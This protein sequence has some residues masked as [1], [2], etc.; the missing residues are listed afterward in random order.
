EG[1]TFLKGTA[2]YFGLGALEIRLALSMSADDINVRKEWWE[3]FVIGVGIKLKDLRLSFAPK[4]EEKKAK[5]D[6]ILWGLQDIL[7]DKP[8]E[9]K[10]KTR[11]SAKKKDKF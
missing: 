6:D 9:Q 11:L 5:N 8:E 3:R 2:G 4:K 1:F 7:D 10:V